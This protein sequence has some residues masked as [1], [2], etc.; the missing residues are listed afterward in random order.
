MI[1]Y[2]QNAVGNQEVWG[3]S[4]SLRRAEDHRA[5]IYI[6]KRNDVRYVIQTQSSGQS[7]ECGRLLPQSASVCKDSEDWAERRASSWDGACSWQ[8]PYLWCASGVPK[9]ESSEESLFCQGIIDL[10]LQT[11][12]CL[13]K[14][15]IDRLAVK[16]F[17]SWVNS[18]KEL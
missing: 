8:S 18:I 5:P 4:Y 2:E 12:F 6:W 17:T 11:T 10:H 16:C 14:L 15:D 3:Q 7:G 13:W 9:L 1:K